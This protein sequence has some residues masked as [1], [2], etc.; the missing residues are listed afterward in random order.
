MNWL[1]RA[2]V[3]W[4][5]S[6]FETCFALVHRCPGRSASFTLPSLVIG[7]FG[8]KLVVMAKA[9]FRSDAHAEILR[10]VFDMSGRGMSRPLA[11]S[12]LG[13]DFPEADATRPGELNAKANNGALTEDERAELEAYIN[14]GDLLAYW[15]S[16]ARQVL[17]QS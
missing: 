17:Q 16:K 10:K 2:Y 3:R 12:I 9:A 8:A 1:T 4:H 15:Q 5:S 11:E 13:L 14:I 6:Y 7:V